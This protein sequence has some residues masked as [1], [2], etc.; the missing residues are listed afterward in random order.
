VHKREADYIFSTCHKY[1]GEEEDWV[2]LADDFRPIA[3]GMQPGVEIDEYCLLFVV[4]MLQ[5]SSFDNDTGHN[6][7]VDTVDDILPCY[8][9]GSGG[10]IVAKIAAS[11]VPPP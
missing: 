1:K 10:Q 8:W 2:Q 7:G 4:S 5:T 6:I 9:F 3:G 11:V